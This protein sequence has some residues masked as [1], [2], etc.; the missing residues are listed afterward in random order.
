MEKFN[1]YTAE[2]SKVLGDSEDFKI[3]V[4]SSTGKT[5]T[6]NLNSDCIEAVIEYFNQIKTN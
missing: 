4:S 1:Y 3:V 5:K 6:M 2:L